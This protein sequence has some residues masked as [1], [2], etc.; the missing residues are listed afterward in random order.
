MIKWIMYGIVGYVAYCYLIKKPE[1]DN[2]ELVMAPDK[3]TNQDLLQAPWQKFP[4]N[5]PQDPR[6]D[7]ADQPWYGDSRAFMGKRD[8]V[9]FNSSEERDTNIVSYNTDEFW[10]TLEE[11]YNQVH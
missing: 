10:K 4:F 3:A 1:G 8:L 2:S 11:R 7:N 5:P 6:V 9:F